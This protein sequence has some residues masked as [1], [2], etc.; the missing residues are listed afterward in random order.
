MNVKLLSVV[1]WTLF[2]AGFLFLISEPANATVSVQI[3]SGD[4]AWKLCEKW[5]N[6][7]VTARVVRDRV[8]KPNRV[9]DPRYL[10]V[11]RWLTIESVNPAVQA[12]AEPVVPDREVAETLSVAARVVAEA[13]TIVKKQMDKTAEET[14]VLKKASD[15]FQRLEKERRNCV[16]HSTVAWTA[17]SVVS[18]AGIVVLLVLV[19][20]ARR[21]KGASVANGTF[22]SGFGRVSTDQSTRC[23]VIGFSFLAKRNG[24]RKRA[25]LVLPRESSVVRAIF[26]GKMSEIAKRYVA[27]RKSLT[28]FFSGAFV[29][30]TDVPKFLVHA[31]QEGRV[32]FSR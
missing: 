27:L 20:S 4:T 12:V 18:V 19:P 2:V 11:G 14:D 10:A 13:S 30:D 28:G 25:W 24:K 32:V 5:C 23:W 3:Q 9:K 26:G 6:E 15:A 1:G 21:R 8:L 7:P 16:T 31:L 22:G 17:T 29:G